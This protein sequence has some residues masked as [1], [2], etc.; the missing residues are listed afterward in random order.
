MGSHITDDDAR[1]LRRAWFD[2]L[3]TVE[4]LRRPLHAYGM[5]LT[6]NVWDAED[7][8]QET[9]LRGFALI[10]RGDLHGAGS[11][12][13]NAR[14]YLFRTA[15]HLFL[16]AERRKA[17]ERAVLAEARPAAAAVG[18]DVV[19]R[20]SAISSRLNSKTSFNSTAARACGE[21]AAAGRASASTA[22]SRALRRS[23][24]RN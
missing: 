23:A 3:D 18:S 2:Y 24:S 14:A 19:R 12:V 20:R 1:A 4:P 15:S 16:D 9:L 13:A 6:G 11:P 22:R 10:G 7:L 17:R 5:R 21:A 8:V